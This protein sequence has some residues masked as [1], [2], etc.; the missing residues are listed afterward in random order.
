M[1]NSDN[2]KNNEKNVSPITRRRR[3]INPPQHD[4]EEKTKETMY[5]LDQLCKQSS[6]AY[7]DLGKANNDLTTHFKSNT[8]RSPLKT[9]SQL[10]KQRRRSVS[11]NNLTQRRRRKEKN[12]HQTSTSIN[13]NNNNNNAETISFM[14]KNHNGISVKRIVSGR[15]HMYVSNLMGFEVFTTKE[16]KDELDKAAYSLINIEQ[17]PDIENVSKM[18]EIIQKFFNSIPLI[19]FDTDNLDGRARFARYVQTMETLKEIIRKMV[20]E[21]Y[22]PGID[23]TNK[24]TPYFLACRIAENDIKH[25]ENEIEALESKLQQSVGTTKE[26]II[27]AFKNIGVEEQAG[28]RQYFVKD[29]TFAYPKTPPINTTRHYG[30]NRPF[31]KEFNNMVVEEDRRKAEMARR[32]NNIVVKQD[33]SKGS[34][35]AAARW[36]GGLKVLKAKDEMLYLQNEM[37]DLQLQYTELQTKYDESQRQLKLAKREA[38]ATKSKLQR[39]SKN[40]TGNRI[41]LLKSNI[42][43][44]A[45]IGK[46]ILT[47]DEHVSLTETANQFALVEKENENLTSRIEMLEKNQDDFITQLSEL[48]NVKYS[49]SVEIEDAI[50]QQIQ[51]LLG[52][53]ENLRIQVKELEL[54]ATTRGSINSDATIR[55]SIT[56]D[57]N[58]TTNNTTSNKKT[59][60]VLR[61]LLQKAMLTTMKRNKAIKMFQISPSQSKAIKE[62]R[63]YEKASKD[64]INNHDLVVTTNTPFYNI[65]KSLPGGITSGISNDRKIA[66]LISNIYADKIVSSLYIYNSI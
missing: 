17:E 48:L 45:V 58:G 59:P 27:N 3:I 49:R 39:A 18:W 30:E 22:K 50:I 26:E 15:Q 21:N 29:G 11:T 52:S 63:H 35:K 36:M 34:A 23:D 55:G 44:A 47:K 65:V 2:N 8:L 31:D 12:N 6:S 33:A 62:K 4:Y 14:D 40:V 57:R 41:N 56:S 46:V 24:L 32:P 20:F 66:R 60:R 37:E 28:L 1:Y 7:L 61:N 38:A 64:Y 42:K 9:S 19:H 51:T 53:H 5:L 16:N 25:L 10:A 54:N 13:S 43:S